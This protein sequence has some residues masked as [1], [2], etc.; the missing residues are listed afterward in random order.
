MH[1]TV[2]KL[3]WFAQKYSTLIIII[4]TG[5]YYKSVCKNDFEGSCDT[6]S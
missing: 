4:I 3:K 2:Q 6:E 5:S 1:T